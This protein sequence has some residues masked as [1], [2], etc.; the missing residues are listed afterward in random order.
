MR[1]WAAL[2]ASLTCAAAAEGIDKPLSPAGDPARGREIVLA[3]ESNCVLCH[4]IPGLERGAAG[5]IGPSLAGVGA[6]LKPAQLRLRIVDSSRL[7][8]AT[9]MP[10]YHRLEGLTGVAR[11]FRGRPILTAQQVEDVVAYLGTLK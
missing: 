3:R 10:P 6:K 5:D 7:N 1:G 4:S 9:I 11:E 2:A 8:P